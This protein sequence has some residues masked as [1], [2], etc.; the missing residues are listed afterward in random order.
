MKELIKDL[1]NKLKEYQNLVKGMEE[2]GIVSFD[3][4]DS[5]TY[6]VF[7]GKAEMLEYVIEKLKTI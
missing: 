1:E 4:E 5:E 2:S 7:V 6:G 3:Y